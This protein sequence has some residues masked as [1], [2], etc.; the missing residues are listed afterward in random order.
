MPSFGMPKNSQR[1]QNE[2]SA[3]VRPDG[4]NDGHGGVNVMVSTRILD[5]DV[6]IRLAPAN[7]VVESGGVL[8]AL[9]NGCLK[10]LHRLDIELNKGAQRSLFARHVFGSGT[11]ADFFGGRRLLGDMSNTIS[12]NIALICPD[13]RT[14]LVNQSP[15]GERYHCPDCDLRLARNGEEF[16]IVRFGEIVGR[17]PIE[18]VEAQV[19]WR[20]LEMA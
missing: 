16:Q 13:C 14:H 11:N 18:D 9:W 2:W 20:M 6:K 4:S 7:A 8:S 10:P 12:G 5:S 19:V 1:R 15:N 3:Q 17:L